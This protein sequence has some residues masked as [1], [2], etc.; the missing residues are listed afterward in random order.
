LKLHFQEKK[1]KTQPEPLT[2][3]K[4][5]NSEKNSQLSEHTLLLWKAKDRAGSVQNAGSS[6]KNPSFRVDLPQRKTQIARK[7]ET[8]S[9]ARSKIRS[10]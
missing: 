4:V 7:R 5:Q 8:E 2:S 6:A 9:E 10:G 3:Y 1:L